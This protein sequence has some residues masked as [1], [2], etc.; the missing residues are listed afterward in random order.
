M[1]RKK[2]FHS[3][4]TTRSGLQSNRHINRLITASDLNLQLLAWRAFSQEFKHI[5]RRSDPP[6]CELFQSIS[7]PKST[8]FRWS[9]W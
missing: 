6:L 4:S 7:D 1:L 3:A 5:R 2:I 8:T 9:A